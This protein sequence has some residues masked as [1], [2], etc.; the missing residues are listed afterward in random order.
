MIFR[1]K[2]WELEQRG[3]AIGWF[4]VGH[5]TCSSPSP[6]TERQDCHWE[7]SLVLTQE[8][9][10]R[11]EKVS[12]IPIRD[13][14]GNSVRDGLRKKKLLFWAFSFLEEN[15]FLSQNISSILTEISPM[16]VNKKT[17]LNRLKSI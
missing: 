6:F 9:A 4:K 5:P 7:D 14:P 1:C 16:S 12:L 15:F 13:K 11:E 8:V 3:A 2:Y 17:F 10:E